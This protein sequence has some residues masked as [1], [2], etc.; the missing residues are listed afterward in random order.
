MFDLFYAGILYRGLTLGDDDIAI[1]TKLCLTGKP[2]RMRGMFSSSLNKKVAVGFAT[3]N[4]TDDKTAVLFIIQW[5]HRRGDHFVV[6]GD[7]R[8]STF[9]EEEITVMD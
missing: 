9:E 5:G 3:A 1:Y 4:L 2:F 6:D 8:Y 7:L